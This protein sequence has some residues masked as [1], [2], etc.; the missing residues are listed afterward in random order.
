M[1]LVDGEQQAKRRRFIR[2]NHPDHGGDPDLFVAGLRRFDEGTDSP[3]P[4]PDD[5][6][7][8]EP[9]RWPVSFVTWLLREFRARRGRG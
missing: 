1:T 3:A 9:E 7:S 6:T 2:A 8:R 5:L 4:P